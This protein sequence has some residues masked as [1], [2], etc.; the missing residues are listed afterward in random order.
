[1]TIVQNIIADNK[2]DETAIIAVADKVL[3]DLKVEA[4]LLLRF[5]D[6]AEVQNLNHKYRN[7]NQPTNV[8]SFPA[9]L[10]DEVD[11][12]ILGDVIICPTIVAAEAKSQNL[13]PTDHLTHLIIHGILHLLNYDHQNQSDTKKMQDLEVK[14]LKTLNIKNPYLIP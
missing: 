12:A 5:V 8:L 4:E 14:I 2:L 11:E 3:A 10:P 13:K 1:M 9:N 7:K 6:E